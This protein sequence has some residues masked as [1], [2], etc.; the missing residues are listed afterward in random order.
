M[1]F[2]LSRRRVRQN[3]HLSRRER[4]WEGLSA[5]C[6][7]GSEPLPEKTGREGLLKGVGKGFPPAV[8]AGFE[9]LPRKGREGLRRNM[10]RGSGRGSRSS[11]WTHILISWREGGRPDVEHPFDLTLQVVNFL[12]RISRY[13]LQ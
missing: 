9:P 13:S 5:Q 2:A 8:H 7:C 11:F 10:G 4:T 3:P 1:N 12:L 6:L